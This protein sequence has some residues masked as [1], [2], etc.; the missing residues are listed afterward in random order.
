MPP[1]APA[2]EA[3]FSGCVEFAPDTCIVERPMQMSIWL[4]V[5]PSTPLLVRIDGKPVPANGR[6]IQGGIRLA[7]AVPE[8]AEVL[9]VET[10][11]QTWSPAVTIAFEWKA[12][13]PID[14]L[15][16]KEL[17][18]FAKKSSGWPRLRA[19]ERLRRM[20]E[21]KP[22]GLSVGE[23]ELALA[24]ELGAVHH[25]ARV[26]GQRAH[27][28]IDVSPDHEEARNALDALLEISE[29]SPFA[30][31]R[32]QYHNAVL[33][34][35]AGDLGSAI[36]GF[37]VARAL[38]ERVNFGVADVVEMLANTLAE[39]GRGEEARPL[40]RLQETHLWKNDP[41][42]FEWL[43]IA[44]N[45]AWGQLVLGAAGLEHDDPRPVLLAA[46]EKADSCPHP[47]REAALLLDL[48]L[49][50]LEY[51]RPLEAQGWLAHLG[52]IPHSLRGWI[53][54]TA[55]AAAFERRDALSMPP[56]LLDSSGTNDFELAWNQSVRRGDLL[57]IWGFDALAAEA[58]L[59]GEH[60]LSATFEQ[61]GTNKGGELYLAGRSA[62][63]TGLVDSLLRMGDAPGASCAIRLARAREFAR[64]DRTARLGAATA[65]ERVRWER[66]LA[67]IAQQRRAVAHG[68]AGLW[69]LSE[70][71]KLQTAAKLS[72]QAR[73]NQEDLDAA[74]RGLGLEPNARSCAE[75]RSPSPGEVILV[76]FAPYIFAINESNTEVSLRADL[77]S[78]QALAGAAR[79]TLVETGADA[80]KPLHLDPWR[81][82]DSLL[83]LA[84]VSYSLDLPPRG[85]SRP[86]SH[87]ALVLADPH[88]DLPAA[89]IEADIV[90]KTLRA[91]SWKVVDLRGENATRSSLFEHTDSVELFHYAG[92][93]VRSGLSGWDS[94]L[95][96]ADDVRF[97]IHDVFTLPAVPSGVVLTG[98][99]TATPNPDTVG[100][101]MNIG[102][103]FVLAGS[104][105]VIAADTEVADRFAADVGSAVHNTETGDGPTRLR[106][107]LLRLRADDPELP[108]EQ[109]RVITP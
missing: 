85:P 23:A 36:A 104:Q 29:A 57:A 51:G 58:Y 65:D 79:I 40:F 103:A 52:R 45:L 42:C 95:L 41:G 102:R 77:S 98:C 47:R 63:L 39:L 44:N 64:L 106:D 67:D 73:Q 9:R 28:F 2:P 83:D 76:A 71:D 96:L 31:A 72:S 54:M 8:G 108:W 6:V 69:E 100:G 13:P 89:R 90:S 99:E 15:S 5:Q 32:W 92:H 88:N 19:L 55:S 80:A 74:I 26:L 50:E 59:A 101:G 20:S 94:A 34:R 24:R 61:V 66:E 30:A 33:A 38:S 7:V 81:N 53:E 68:Q 46:L 105:W 18:A 82:S 4:D 70:R 10:P 97:G 3:V 93:G 17:R 25:Q 84:P 91:A 16:P 22:S 37:E 27:T 86:R 60:Q 12:R 1:D 21:G 87:T 14:D 109:F 107:A 43:R 11:E 78:L 62:S 56:L 75:L 48:A 35:R 49:A